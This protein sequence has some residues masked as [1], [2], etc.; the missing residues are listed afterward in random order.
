MS[1]PT[2]KLDDGNFVLTVGIAEALESL[3]DDDKRDIVQTLACEESIIDHVLRQLAHG[4][5]ESG[6]YGYWGKH[7]RESVLRDTL[8]PARFYAVR[9]AMGEKAWADKRANDAQREALHYENLAQNL[10]DKLIGQG[11]DSQWVCFKRDPPGTYPETMTDAQVAE[12]MAK[13]DEEIDKAM[14]C[15]TA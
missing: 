8:E 2:I 6:W 15:K 3:T 11:F 5:T 14:R 10:N 7:K 1:K 12:Y 9:S 13:A 4:C